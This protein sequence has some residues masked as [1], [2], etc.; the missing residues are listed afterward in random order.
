MNGNRD[1]GPSD[2]VESCYSCGYLCDTE[3]SDAVCS[4]C[5]ATGRARY[6]PR[7]L[8]GLM[9]ALIGLLMWPI[10][11]HRYGFWTCRAARVSVWA[12]WGMAI[13][14][15][16]LTTLIGCAGIYLICRCETKSVIQAPHP[17]GLRFLIRNDSGDSNQYA[18]SFSDLIRVPSGWRLE[19]S[20]VRTL[21]RYY[22]L[23][24]AFIRQGSFRNHSFIG[25][26]DV[27]VQSSASWGKFAGH[28]L[29]LSSTPSAT[30][31]L[32][33]KEL[34]KILMLYMA[35]PLWIWLGLF[36]ISILMH[37]VLI[38]RGVMSSELANRIAATPLAVAPAVGI[39][40][41]ICTGR[42]FSWRWGEY[43]HLI[44]RTSVANVILFFGIVVA[45]FGASR[46][47]HDWRG[48]RE[49]T[50]VIN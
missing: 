47:W 35:P 2:R 32:N 30:V 19:V 6:G 23:N 46:I 36:V 16:F 5:G 43:G 12:W 41:V 50:V 26:C 40:V 31:L 42:E 48:H 11:S 44:M 49:R 17:D 25:P 7:S 3:A 24:T 9:C 45:L 39:A 38:L 21:V 4:D 10:R 27:A 14:A 29:Y 33:R 22:Q 18:S 34:T 37:T 13:V 15:V 8:L 20:G 28:S 1:Q